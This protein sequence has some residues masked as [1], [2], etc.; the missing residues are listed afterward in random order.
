MNTRR[1]KKRMRTIADYYVK[2][3]GGKESPTTCF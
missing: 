3:R 1:K 2:L